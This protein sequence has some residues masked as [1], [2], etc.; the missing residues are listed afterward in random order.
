M[1]QRKEIVFTI[2]KK[3]KIT[4]TIKGIKGSGCS[5]YVEKLKCMGNITGELRTDEYYEGNNTAIRVHGAT[6]RK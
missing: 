3:G 1:M 6:G 5:T 2:G 4:S